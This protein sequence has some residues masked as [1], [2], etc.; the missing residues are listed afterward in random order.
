MTLLVALLLTQAP[1]GS[2]DTDPYD[3]ALRAQLSLTPFEAAAKGADFA[4]RTVVLPSFHPEC[5]VFLVRRNSAAEMTVHCASQSIWHRQVSPRLEGRKAAPPSTILVSRFALTTAEAAA[6]EALAPAIAA[7]KEDT[8]QVGLDGMTTRF[9]VAAAGQPTK[10]IDVWHRG[11]APDAMVKLLAE[12][13]DNHHG[14]TAKIAK[15]R[16]EYLKH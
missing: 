13:I 1:V 15:Y 4:L 6:V 7:W 8:S 3:A 10:A 16:S 14:A 2:G 12:I 9:E 11:G 5:A